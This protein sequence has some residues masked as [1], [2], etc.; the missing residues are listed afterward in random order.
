MKSIYG[1]VVLWT[2]L[3]F[4]I[5]SQSFA[6]IDFKYRHFTIEDGLPNMHTVAIVQDPTGFLWMGTYDGLVRYDGY[7]FKV[8]KHEKVGNRRLLLRNRIRNLYLNPINGLLFIQL[9][10]YQYSCYDTKNRCFIDFTGGMSDMHALYRDIAFLPDG[11]TWLLSKL[12][13]SIEIKYDKGKITSRLHQHGSEMVHEIYKNYV[14]ERYH[15]EKSLIDRQGYKW[16]MTQLDGLHV[17]DTST[18]EVIHYTPDTPGSPIT[19]NTLFAIYEDR[20]GNIWVCQADMGLVCITMASRDIVH[21]LMTKMPVPGYKNYARMLKKAQDGNIYIGNRENQLY[22]VNPTTLDIT[23]IPN[24]VPDDDIL[25]ICFDKD[26]NKWMGTRR[27]GILINGVPHLGYPDY[28]KAFTQERINDIMRDSKDRLWIGAVNSGIYMA[29]P[30]AN[31]ELQFRQ[32]LNC[33][34]I[35][36]EVNIIRQLKDGTICVGFGRGL[37]VF[38]PEELIADTTKYIFY[39]AENSALASEEIRDILED[40]DGNVWIATV[41]AGVFKATGDKKKL[42]FKQ[43]TAQDGLANDLTCSLQLDKKGNLW[44][45]TEYG[46]SLYNKKSEQFTNLFPCT[47]HLGNLISEKASTLLDD[48]RLLF[49]TENGIIAFDPDSVQLNANKNFNLT[50]T[51]L[52]VNGTSYDAMTEDSIVNLT[53]TIKLRHTQ[54]SL[55]FNFSDFEYVYPKRT[56]YYYKLEGLDANWTMTVGNEAVY[57]ELSPGKYTFFVRTLNADGSVSE[58]IA[59]KVQILQPWWNTWWAWCIYLLAIAG[60]C[61]VLYRQMTTVYRLKSRV[62]VERKLADFKSRFFMNISHEFRTPLTLIRGS[63]EKLSNRNNL[64]TDVRQTVN[65]MNHSVERMLRLVNQLLEYNKMQEGKLH[66]GVQ[67]TD[68]IQFVNRLCPVFFDMAERRNMKFQVDTFADSHTLLLDRSAADKI[69]Y[70]LLSN[71]FKYTPDGGEVSISVQQDKEKKQ[72]KI[73]V[74]DTGVGISKEKQK[75]LFSRFMDSAFAADS[76]GIGLN[77]TKEL[78][79]LHHGSI[80]YSENPQG[81]SIFTVNLPDENIYADNEMAHEITPNSSLNANALA[82]PDQTN[83]QSMLTGESANIEIDAA[84]VAPLNDK[85]ILIIEDDTD[86][87]QFLKEE[88]EQY[89]KVQLRHDGAAGLEEAQQNDYDLIICDVMMPKMNGYEVVSRLKSKFDTCHIPIILLTAL[90]AEENQL[91][92]IT[93][94]A[95]AYITKP[96]SPRLL[97]ARVIQLIDQ[98]N[99]IRERFA[100]ETTTKETPTATSICTNPLDKK[101][102]E[103]FNKLLNE[104]LTDPDLSLDELARELAVGRTVFFRKVKGVTGFTPNEYIRVMR[105]KKAA[106][107]LA[108]GEYTVNDTAYSVGYND[109]LYFSRCFKQQFGVSPSA[110]L[111]GERRQD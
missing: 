40:R 84:T 38:N 53:E 59:M 58:E 4:G 44:I 2:M 18:G 32:M 16:T 29:Q 11:T 39:S 62:R 28:P 70:N 48:G 31:G 23:E 22:T 72:V 27:H 13:S 94:G 65:N 20:G 100:S 57:R 36:N 68:I 51:N 49:G 95:D 9:R 6:Q 88:M 67:Q 8:F 35:R 87:C 83:N 55:T 89:F 7:S 37:A 97:L 109:P 91:K 93:T 79:A 56:K 78:V 108:E 34:D 76:I 26:G 64:A 77:L 98:R 90:G 61:W 71:A 21:R 106:E 14:D 103:K 12:D 25:C 47:D 1:I 33:P 10:N 85:R 104:R 43:Y 80:D 50:F 75:D 101:F 86:V 63:V 81:G 54:N 66:L 46:I 92:G 69:I 45:G 41:G 107:M 102:M 30:D 111:K 42:H 74:A 24:P 60:L 99:R 17:E 110:Y 15:P 52:S 5:C 82:T 3:L 19:T 96:F 73:V 105:L